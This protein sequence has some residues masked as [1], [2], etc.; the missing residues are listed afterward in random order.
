MNQINRQGMTTAA[1][2]RCPVC[3]RGA[4]LVHSAERYFHTDGTDNDKCWLAIL[5]G[6]V[7]TRRWDCPTCGSP[8]VHLP[9]GDGS[10]TVMNQDDNSAHHC[11]PAR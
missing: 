8:Q 6:Q 4:F 5:R 9:N 3:D 7:T 1:I 2:D 10:F 11:V